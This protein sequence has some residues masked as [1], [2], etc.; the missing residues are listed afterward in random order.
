MRSVKASLE[1]IQFFIEPA[2]FPSAVKVAPVAWHDANVKLEVRGVVL[3]A[4][5]KKFPLTVPA[6]PLS[7][8]V[9]SPTQQQPAAHEQ[10]SGNR[11]TPAHPV[12]EGADSPHSAKAL[13]VPPKPGAGQR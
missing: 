8:I 9:N 13:M 5:Q 7:E 2:T 1:T 10:V 11:Y 6:R 3:L 4:P 12:H